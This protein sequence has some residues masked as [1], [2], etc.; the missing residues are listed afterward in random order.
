[1]AS[2]DQ[3]RANIPPNAV[4]VTV[5]DM[6]VLKER[7]QLSGVEYD[8]QLIRQP[9]VGTEGLSTMAMYMLHDGTDL[10]FINSGGQNIFST[11]IDAIETLQVLQSLPHGNSA[12]YAGARGGFVR[13]LREG[14]SILISTPAPVAID[15]TMHF[16]TIAGMT[17]TTGGWGKQLEP[18][19]GL[20]IESKAV[21]DLNG[22][23]KA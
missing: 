3:V 11:P 8:S 14:R 13:N 9:I 19:G 18:Y 20:F 1:M 5:V 21:C 23:L 12:V 17:D 16:K 22:I 7:T 15:E 6:L 10:I 2:L 4:Y